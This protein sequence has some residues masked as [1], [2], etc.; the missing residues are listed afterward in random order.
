MFNRTPSRLLL[1]PFSHVAI[2]AQRLASWVG[3]HEYSS[4]SINV[5]IILI[6]RQQA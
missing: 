5:N 3:I 6:Q 2:T 4:L 1:E